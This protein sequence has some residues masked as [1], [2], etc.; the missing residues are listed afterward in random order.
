MNWHLGNWSEIAVAAATVLVVA[1]LFDKPPR[2]PLPS[3]LSPPPLYTHHIYIY[4]VCPFQLYNMWIKS[5][6]CST[7]FIWSYGLG[8]QANWVHNEWKHE[9]K[10]YQV[11][12]LAWHYFI[13]MKT[14]ITLEC[15]LGEEQT[16]TTN[17]NNSNNNENYVAHGYISPLFIFNLKWC[18]LNRCAWE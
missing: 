14:K 16:T 3:P 18:R 12:S 1:T 13:E 6:C 7:S 10:S 2:S 15:V 8:H 9:N 17:N 4:P 11:N 5:A